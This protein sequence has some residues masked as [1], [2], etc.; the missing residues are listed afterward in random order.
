[1]D[2][3]VKVRRYYGAIKVLLVASFVCQFIGYVTP[4]WIYLVFLNDSAYGDNFDGVKIDGELKRK[5]MLSLWYV[6]ACVGNDSLCDIFSL[7]DIDE[8]K[9]MNSRY[10]Y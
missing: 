8:T 6:V 10:R 7:S 5:F 4:G 2:D 3:Q 9:Y 1:M